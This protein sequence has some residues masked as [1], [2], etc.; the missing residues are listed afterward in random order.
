MKKETP[1]T[2]RLNQYIAKS[3]ITSRRK[4]DLLIESGKIKING[5]IIKELG[6]QVLL[7]DIVEYRDK[8]IEI[9]KCQF[10]IIYKGSVV[11]YFEY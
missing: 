1:K 3:G 7:N 11:A 10:E 4:A 2:Y 8:K 9:E 5:H 6:T